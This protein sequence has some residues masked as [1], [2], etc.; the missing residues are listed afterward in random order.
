MKNP[1]NRKQPGASWGLH[2]EP[3]AWE[4][5]HVGPSAFGW[6]TGPPPPPPHPPWTF[7]KRREATCA[8]ANHASGPLRAWS[9]IFGHI[10][11]Y[12]PRIGGLKNN[13]DNISFSTRKSANVWRADTE[14]VPTL[15]NWVLCNHKPVLGGGRG[16]ESSNSLDHRHCFI[17]IINSH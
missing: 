15:E 17:I 14:R 11:V 13:K 6:L 12:K 1:E 3:H 4:R 8:G 10:Y 7:C 2:E 9:S 5:P 16:G